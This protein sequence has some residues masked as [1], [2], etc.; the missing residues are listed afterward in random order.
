MKKMF[1]SLIFFLSCS[2]SLYILMI[3]ILCQ[4][5]I[6]Q[7]F[8]PI[9]ELAYFLSFFKAEM[10][11]LKKNIYLC[12]YLSIYLLAVLGLSCGMWASL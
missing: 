7:I 4:I 10:A 1:K 11:V 5:Y 6:L 12:I 2:N 8:S 9:L 3:L